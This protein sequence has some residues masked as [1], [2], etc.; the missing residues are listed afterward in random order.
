M[1]C[2]W[3]AISL[4]AALSANA[5]ELSEA[6]FIAQAAKAEQMLTQGAAV[7]AEI[8]SDTQYSK[9]K[10]ANE[11][12][13]T[14][15]QQIAAQADDETINWSVNDEKILR[16][17]DVHGRTMA[18]ELADSYFTGWRTDNPEIL[19]LAD[20]EGVTVAHVLA[21]NNAYSQLKSQCDTKKE[22]YELKDGE[23]CVPSLKPWHTDNLAILSLADN[24]GN[25]VAHVLA[26]T[27]QNDWL[28]QDTTVLM[29]KNKK[30]LSVA[31]LLAE[32]PVKNWDTN[33]IDVLKLTDNAGITVVH[34][35]ADHTDKKTWAHNE[36][37]ILSLFDGSGKS[38][39][40]ILARAVR[41]DLAWT[42]Q[43]SDILNLKVIDGADRFGN[44]YEGGRTVLEILADSGKWA[45]DDLD[46]LKQLSY[47]K[48]NI[49]EGETIAHI[50]ADQNRTWLPKDAS[51]LLWED[52][53][54]HSV[55]HNL[56]RRS[57]IWV[58][59][60]VN[61]LKLSDDRGDSVA[62]ILATRAVDDPDW[63][64]SA[65]PWSSNNPEI[66]SLK[67]DKGVSVAKILQSNAAKPVE[68]K[69]SAVFAKAL[70]TSQVVIPITVSAEDVAAAMGVT[71][72]SK[73][74]L[75]GKCV[76]DIYNG[77][78]NPI[79]NIDKGY[80]RVIHGATAKGLIVAQQYYPDG[81]PRT[82]QL[83]TS[84]LQEN[85]LGIE[86]DN[87]TRYIYFPNHNGGYY[88]Q[89]E[90]AYSPSS[91]GPISVFDQDGVKIN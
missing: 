22:Y 67:N 72:Q 51:I 53:A 71:C 24:E 80:V 28:T 18:H 75:P 40:H 58:T 45:T 15:L 27:H 32:N 10:S 77:L 79:T 1:K 11:R 19:K 41:Y 29:L 3:I 65:K 70:K 30:G 37:E 17:A 56:A 91:A 63:G 16:L 73:P 89:F 84:S 7:S 49:H 12:P 59:D 39:A 57:S 36:K 44:R 61:I 87:G 8:L 83:A 62:H 6:A 43:D 52:K 34:K 78:G 86:P 26:E 2:K 68:K 9:Y 38:V 60:D 66:L 46:L 54:G 21:E 74:Q 64:T 85:T 42:T 48:Y 33:N 69:P 23:E 13:W 35:L 90:Q 88:I 55:A 5:K 50:L 81:M 14:I 4:L 25:T 31:H 76:F 20:D 47:D 82:N